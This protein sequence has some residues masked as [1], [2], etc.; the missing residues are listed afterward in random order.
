VL[1]SHV[2]MERTSTVK[3]GQDSERE[4]KKKRLDGSRTKANEKMTQT[5][6]G[7]GEGAGLV[8]FL[9]TC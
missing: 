5:I 7:N 2:Y 1:P 3:H 9:D 8:P 4:G 6:P